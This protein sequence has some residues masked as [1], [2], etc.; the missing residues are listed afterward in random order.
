MIAELA[1]VRDVCVGEEVVVGT[2]DGGVAF[3]SGAVDGDVFAEGVVSADAG[4]GGAT[5]MFKV[6]R[7]EADAGEG[8]KRVGFA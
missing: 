3:V 2:D 6:L 7:L 4:V 8:V 1:I 5:G